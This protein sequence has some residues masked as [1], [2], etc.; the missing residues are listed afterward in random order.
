MVDYVG[1]GNGSS[2]LSFV[3]ALEGFECGEGF[4][5][6]LQAKPSRT[7]SGWVFF[8][9]D[10]VNLS[11]ERSDSPFIHGVASSG[12]KGVKPWFDCRI[13]PHLKFTD[14]QLLDAR[15][16]GFEQKLVNF[17]GELIPPGGHL[18]LDYESEGNEET[19]IGLVCGVPPIVTYLGY[20]M[21]CA[22]FRGR[23]KDWYFPEG[24]HEGVRKLQANKPLTEQIELEALQ[25]HRAQLRLFVDTRIDPAGEHAEVI[26]AAKQRALSLLAD[27][28]L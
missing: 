14:G 20:M 21:F 8:A 24:G 18:M 23:F 4:F 11:G 19:F 15:T 25:E 13:R 12:G 10:L 28:L 6:S 3:G 2:A 7:R 26:L 17:L 1:Q 22:G 16:L 27:Q 5:L 9:A